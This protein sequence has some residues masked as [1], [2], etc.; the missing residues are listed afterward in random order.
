MPHLI[1]V[2]LID[3]SVKPWRTN[4]R[5]SL[6]R[7]SRGVGTGCLL[8]MARRLWW[9]FDRVKMYIHFVSGYRFRWAAAVRAGIPGLGIVDVCVV[10]DT[11]L[12]RVVTLVNVA[13]PL[14]SQEQILNDAGMG[15]ASGALETVDREP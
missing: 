8:F 5:T 1:V 14:A 11:I 7:V 13:V 2:R 3:K 15:F 9:D 12:T 4:A 6:R 10:V